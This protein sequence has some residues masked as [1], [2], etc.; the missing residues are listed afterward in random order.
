[1]K[2]VAILVL[3][4]LV[5]ASSAFPRSQKLWP[6][7]IVGGEEVERHELPFQVSF[8]YF[9]SHICGGSILDANT[10]ITAAHCCDVSTSPSSFSVSAGRHNIEQ[11]NEELAQTIDVSDFVKHENY[12]ATGKIDNDICLLKLADSLNFDEGSQP[13]ALPAAGVTVTG[14]AVVSGWGTTSSGG[15]AADI[16]RK[17]TVPVVTDAKCRQAYGQADILDSM[18]CAGL[19]EGGKDSCQG[20]SGGPMTSVVN[21]ERVLSGIVSWGY[22]CAEPGYPGV[23]TEVSH[24]IEWIAENKA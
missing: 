7:R 11:N 22:G 5:A 19:D 24:F 20:D 8:Q 23:Y 1:M 15:G 16:L 6:V 3:L 13:I 17:V 10:I 2:A 14:D 12:D 4:G 9:G 21:G 18:I